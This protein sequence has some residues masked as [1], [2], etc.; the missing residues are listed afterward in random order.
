MGEFFLQFIREVL[1]EV[2]G[3]F[4]RWLFLRKNKSF[5][6]VLKDRSAYNVILSFAIIGLIVLSLIPNR[7]KEEKQA[8]LLA[9]REA[10]LGWLYLKIYNDNTFEFESRGLERKGDIYNGTVSISNDTLYFSYKDSIPAI[11]KKAILTKNSVKYFDGQYK[12][13]LELKKNQLNSK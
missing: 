11:G 7:K 4:I 6:D 12:D 10:P 1:M 3:A 2:P 8:L 9:G 13:A 5:G